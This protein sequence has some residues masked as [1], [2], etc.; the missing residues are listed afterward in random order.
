M[1]SISIQSPTVSPSGGILGK[2]DSSPTQS[3]R[4]D[5]GVS[6]IIMFLRTITDFTAQY[7]F[8]SNLLRLL[9]F[10]CK[11][12]N[13]RLRLLHINAVLHL[14]PILRLSLQKDTDLYNKAAETILLVMGSL[15]NESTAQKRVLEKEKDKQKR[16]QILSGVVSNS[17]KFSEISYSPKIESGYMSYDFIFL[18]TGIFFF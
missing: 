16:S 10:C 18:C 2:Q 15:L 3:S 13:C 6:E 4:Y 8:A 9:K 14:M 11:N 1:S 12:K 17:P 5:D 7:E